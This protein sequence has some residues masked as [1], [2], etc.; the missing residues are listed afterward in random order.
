MGVGYFKGKT[1]LCVPFGGKWESI[2]CS[3]ATSHYGGSV[4]SVKY[5]AFSALKWNEL[6]TLSTIMWL[7]ATPLAL[8]VSK[9]Q[10]RLQLFFPITFVLPVFQL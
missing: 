6:S 4:I 3:K 8:D 2:F 5:N 9:P 10:N 1:D 7:T